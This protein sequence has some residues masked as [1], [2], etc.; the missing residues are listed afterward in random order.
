MAEVIRN[1]KFE[2]EAKKRCAQFLLDMFQK[3]GAEVFEENKNRA[4][5]DAQ[6]VE[7]KED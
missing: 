5:G 2:Q 1:E 6:K 7:D 3:Y 4:C